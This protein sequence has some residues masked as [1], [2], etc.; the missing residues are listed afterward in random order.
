LPYLNKNSD[1]T[2][3]LECL[4][5]LSDALIYAYINEHKNYNVITIE[6]ENL[7][8][9]DNYTSKRAA[10]NV[11]RLIEIG[12]NTENIPSKPL[13]ELNMLKLVLAKVLLTNDWKDFYN[14]YSVA[15]LSNALVGFG[16]II[17][18]IAYS[19]YHLHP[20]LHD[21][22]L[23]RMIDILYRNNKVYAL[24]SNLIQLSY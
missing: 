16:G 6:S 9:F 22:L 3:W 4:G 7:P 18:I 1:D 23:S 13:N 20:D 8:E 2:I 21:N 5:G 19:L 12:V 10:E 17:S 15:T 11:I 14:F 24:Y